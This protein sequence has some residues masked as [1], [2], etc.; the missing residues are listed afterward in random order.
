MA[1]DAFYAVTGIHLRGGEL[2]RFE[3]K[4]NKIKDISYQKGVWD[5]NT[6]ITGSVILKRFGLRGVA[7]DLED[8]WVL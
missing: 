1:L 7:D 8:L 3:E 2:L 6:G 5:I 4:F